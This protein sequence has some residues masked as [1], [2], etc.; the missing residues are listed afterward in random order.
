MKIVYIGKYF[1][2]YFGGIETVSEQL[3]EG[4][5]KLGHDVSV[6]VSHERTW[7]KSINTQNS[8]DI[9]KLRSLGRIT[10][11]PL[12]LWSADAINNLKP[13]IIHFHLPNPL[14]LFLI[15]KL[16]GIKIATYHA[17]IV[18]KGLLGRIYS[19][20]YKKQINSFDK[21]ILTSKNTSNEKNFLNLCISSEKIVEIPLGVELKNVVKKQINENKKI[22]LVFSGRL[23]EY[24]GLEYLIK[25]MRQIDAELFI[26]G[27]GVL[28]LKLIQLT[29]KLKLKHKIIFMP[30]MTRNNLLNF[31]NSC[32]LFVL[33]SISEAEAFGMSALEAMSLGVPVVTTNLNSG[34]SEINIDGLTG[35][36]VEPRSAKALA[37]GINEVLDI[38]KLETLGLKAR[39]RYVENYTLKKMIS[40]HS[41]LYKSL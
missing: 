7:H 22:K 18:N 29:E 32:N 34:V 33:P 10:S 23:V 35:K 3:A 36:I 40:A 38:K 11:V 6:M 31:I 41:E 30:P 24:K 8:Y 25:A 1:K 27:D 4:M 37:L 16:S 15:N 19:K 20:K 39:D 17:S 2:P 21:I 13:D 12:C 5:T 9:I 26:I 14:P 28:K